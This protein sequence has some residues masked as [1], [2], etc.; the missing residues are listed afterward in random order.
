MNGC[1]V[2]RE[3]SVVSKINTIF[4]LFLFTIQN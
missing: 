4:N 2:N 3:T 1:F